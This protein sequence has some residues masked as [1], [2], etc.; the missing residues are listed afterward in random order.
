[1][2]L[3][4]VAN[5]HSYIPM[6]FTHL[7]TND[8]WI[9][10]K[11][12][13]NCDWFYE[14]LNPLGQGRGFI[15]KE[16]LKMREKNYSKMCWSS[17]KPSLKLTTFQFLRRTCSFRGRCWASPSS[18]TA[19]EQLAGAAEVPPGPGWWQPKPPGWSSNPKWS[20]LI[21][22]GKNQRSCLHCKRLEATLQRACWSKA[23]RKND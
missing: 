3:A 21:K 15:K 16:E 13:Q 6:P 19:R 14:L 4:T 12:F 9:D 2:K 23:L 1:M 18:G 10:M 20:R 22:M 17:S 11:P 8:R 5:P 7:S